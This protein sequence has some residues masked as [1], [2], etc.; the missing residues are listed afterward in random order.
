MNKNIDIYAETNP[1]FC[2]LVL[3]SFI[4]A[5]YTETGR[6]ISFP[7]LLL[8]IPIVLSGDLNKSFDKTTKRTSFFT[9]IERNPNIRFNLAERIQNSADYI[10]PAIEYGFYK[11]IFKLS[12]KGGVIPEINAVKKYQTNPVTKVTFKKAEKLG[13]W[14]SQVNSERTIFNHLEI[15]L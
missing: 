12:D 2:S 1:A 15:Q 6:S 14:L 10:K 7:L 5:Y 3:L 4:N 11:G 13:Y 9:W 8:P